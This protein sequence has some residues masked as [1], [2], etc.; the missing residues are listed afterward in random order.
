LCILYLINPHTLDGK[1]KEPCRR[2]QC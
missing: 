2:Q 1:H